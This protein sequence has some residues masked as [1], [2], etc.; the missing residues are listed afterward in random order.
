MKVLELFAGTKSIGKAFEANGHEV[1]SI[2]WDKDFENIDLYADI[3][4]VTAE[5]II[6]KFGRPDVIWA[7]PD[8]ST[9]SIAAISHHRRKNPETGT[10]DPVSDYAKFCD[11]VDKHVLELIRELKPKYWFIENPRGGMRKMEWMQGLPRYTVTYCQ[12]GDTRMK[13]TDIWTNHPNPQFKPMCKNGDKCHEPAPR[14]S[15]TGTQGLKGS[16]KRSVIP[17][18]LCEHIV[19]I[20]EL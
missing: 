8:C 2:E 1:F 11:E 17:T 15:K 10:L 12:Y 16:K 19:S 4:T 5:E 14:G 18:A 3:N 6:E 13:P 9:F 7:S 20:C